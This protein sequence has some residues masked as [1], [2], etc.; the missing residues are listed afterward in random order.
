MFK[1]LKEKLKIFKKKAAEELM[2]GEETEKKPV[3][4]KKK[5]SKFARKRLGEKAASLDEIKREDLIVESGGLFAKRISERRLDEVLWD[6]ELS[7]LEADVAE[8]VV[9]EIKSFVRERL[10]GAKISRKSDV[11]EVI[12]D[13]LRK[14]IRHVLEGRRLDL[15]ERIRQGKRPFV[16]MFVGV[17]GTGK[18]T[19]IA[20]IANR[21][22]KQGLIPVIAAADTFRAGAIEQLE[23][24]AERLGV[25]LIKHQSGSD[26][27][28]VA[29][30]AIEHAKAR[31][32]DVV[33]I[34]T[35]G[36]M[37]TNVNLMDEMKKIKR[38][39]KPDLVIFVGD[40]LAGN[41]AVE[42]ARKFHEAVGL[43]GAVLTKIDA[44][45]KGGAALSIAYA[46][47]VPII[48]MGT[49]Q[50]YDD[51]QEFNPSW[52]VDRIFGEAEV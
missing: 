8:E 21:L 36:R 7:L 9:E 48:Y 49:G 1:S 10:L 5:L 14:G 20:K 37:Q 29:Y 22:K 2:E 18:T 38:V 32:K 34:D 50:E 15:D 44:D 6:L 28:A 25:K 41:D 31:R 43:D 40:A 16:I 33:L 46:V 51:L 3:P 4:K 23:K 26:P 12:E 11:E 19:T 27:A 30:D 13:A 45:A 47:G 52:M 42:Q 35:A 24:H 17:N 39:A